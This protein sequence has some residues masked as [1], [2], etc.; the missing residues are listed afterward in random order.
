MILLLFFFSKLKTINFSQIQFICGSS[1]K[2]VSLSVCHI[3]IQ[4]CKIHL[5][6]LLF[7]LIVSWWWK[8]L[9]SR[10][11]HMIVVARKKCSMIKSHSSLKILP[12]RDLLSVVFLSGSKFLCFLFWFLAYFPSFFNNLQWSVI[13]YPA[14]PT[15]QPLF[16]HP[17]APTRPLRIATKSTMK[18]KWAIWCW[19]KIPR[20]PGALRCFF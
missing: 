2:S 19:Q 12:F 13:N 15:Y 7:C 6:F 17:T 5:R 9:L 3:F 16:T 1:C 10:Y 20:G 11:V 8:G 14:S 18:G 4:I